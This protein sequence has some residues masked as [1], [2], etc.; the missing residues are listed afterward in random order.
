MK[1]AGTTVAATGTAP[2][3]VRDTDAGLRGAIDFERTKLQSVRS[4]AWSL[5]A[6]VALIGAIG[7]ILGLSM[8]ASG[9]NDFDV[10]RPAPQAALEGILLAQLPFLAV[11]TLAITTEYS[12]G[13]ITTTL[14][15]VPRR[16]RVLLAKVVVVSIVSFICGVVLC[17]VGTAAVA[18]TAGDYGAFTARE[19]ALTAL[20]SGYYLTTTGLLALGLGTLLRSAAATITT[21]TMLLLAVPQLLRLSTVDWLDDA[22]SYLPDTAG[23]V[24]ISQGSQPY[25]LVTAAAVLTAWASAAMLGGYRRLSRQ[26]A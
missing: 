6:G 1:T 4:T 16:G 15:S 13:S 22:S 7:V 21:I 5:L 10:S 2:T 12:T 26:D 19:L 11:A 20:A 8:T 25:G 9:D 24:L 18:P 17:L 23:T 14:Q 3:T